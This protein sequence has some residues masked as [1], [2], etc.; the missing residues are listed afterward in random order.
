MKAYVIASLQPEFIDLLYFQLWIM[1]GPIVK[2]WNIKG[3]RHYCCKHK[4]IRK[5]D[6]WSLYNFF[7][8]VMNVVGQTPYYCLKEQ[9]RYQSCTGIHLLIH[10]EISKRYIFKETNNA[11]SLKIKKSYENKCLTT[12]WLCLWMTWRMKL[13]MKAKLMNL[14]CKLLLDL[15]R[16][17][18]LK[19][20]TIYAQNYMIMNS[21]LWTP[22]YQV[23]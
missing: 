8:T 14:L 1:L 3:L 15:S 13:L 5:N 19:I 22:L 16:S 11:N 20:F 6:L 10:S 21:G 12:G 18:Y 7:R 23:L 9:A 2:V 17:W 4:R